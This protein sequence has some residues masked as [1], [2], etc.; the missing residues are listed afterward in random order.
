MWKLSGASTNLEPVSTGP[1]ISA[2][3][4]E[5]SRLTRLSTTSGI[6]AAKLS[7]PR[8]SLAQQA[9]IPQ[10]AGRPATASEELSLNYPQ[11]IPSSPPLP[12][13]NTSLTSPSPNPPPSP[14]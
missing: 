4:P 6:R 11:N 1:E 7:S 2:L 13:S 9:R 12:S 10:S 3:G 5:E 14:S 8:I